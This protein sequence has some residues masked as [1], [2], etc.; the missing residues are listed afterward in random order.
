MLSL[1][2]MTVKRL[3]ILALL[4][5][6]QAKPL[7]VFEEYTCTPLTITGANKMRETQT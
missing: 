6:Q 1:T 2:V 4:H 5:K 7:Q 3:R